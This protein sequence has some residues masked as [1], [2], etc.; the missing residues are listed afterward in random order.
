MLTV[1][2]PRYANG[3]RRREL[4]TRKLA[5]G[6]Y[7]SWPDCPWPW[8]Y[9]GVGLVEEIR[10]R[11]PVKPQH[12]PHYPEVDEIIPVSRGGD[13]VAADNTRLLHRR[14]WCNSQRSN[15][16]DPPDKARPRVIESSPGW[17]PSK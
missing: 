12:D 6:G 13:P 15:K 17:G 1:G 14:R 10:Q 16:P 4:R 9:L 2:N 5:A 7:C 8:E 3:H 11:R